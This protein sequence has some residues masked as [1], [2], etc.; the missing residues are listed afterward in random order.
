LPTLSD[1]LKDLTGKLRDAAQTNLAN[2][3]QLSMNEIN[4]LGNNL[5][6]ADNLPSKKYEDQAWQTLA[7]GHRALDVF[8]HELNIYSVAPVAIFDVARVWPVNEGV[9]YGVGPGLRLSLVNV[10]FTI[11]YGFNLQRASRESIGAIFFKLDV[12]SLF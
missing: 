5:R 2:Q 1:L 4:T 11:S 10:N 7:P 12:T 9:H 8:L 3:I 6:D